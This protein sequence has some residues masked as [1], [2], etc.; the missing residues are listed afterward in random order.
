MTVQSLCGLPR[1]SATGSPACLL[2][3]KLVFSRA[4][5]AAV[6]T[7]GPDGRKPRASALSSNTRP[8][9]GATQPGNV[10]VRHVVEIMLENHTFDNL[11][12]GLPVRTAYHR[13]P[14]SPARQCRRSR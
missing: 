9:E 8:R 2:P 4:L 3:V 10:P 14:L 7:A 5:V 13:V 11:F 1:R 12:G 6:L